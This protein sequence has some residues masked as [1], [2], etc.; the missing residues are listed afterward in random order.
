MNIIRILK[1][2]NNWL[3]FRELLQPLSNKEKG[4]CFELLTWY[5]LKLEPK[6][7]SKLDFVWLLNE[8]PSKV[9]RHI[10]LP[11]QDEGIDLLAKTKEGEYWAIQCKYRDDENL[12]LTRK[13]LSTFTDLS[14]SICKNISLG[15]VCTTTCGYS[16][17]L[18]LYGDRVA[19]CT[20]NDWQKLDSE[21]FHRLHRSFV[22]EPD[23]IEPLKPRPHQEDAITNAYNHF[24]VENNTRGKMIMP[25]GTGKSLAAYWITEQLD[26]KRILVL[27]PSIALIRQTLDVWLRQAIADNKTVSWICVCSDQTLANNDNYDSSIS[28][29]DLGIQIHTNP[30]EIENWLKIKRDG[31]TVIFST[32]Q[33]GKALSEAS[34][35]AAFTFDVG[36][37]DEAHKTVG[38]KQGL[39]S[40]PLSDNFISINKRIFMTATERRYQGNNNN[41]VGM[42]DINVYGETFELLSF[43][44]ALDM[45][46]PILCNYKIAA[47]I[48]DKSEI[49]E[50]IE[51]NVFLRPNIDE[52]DDFI[53]AQML[54]S[55]V[56]LRK[57]FDDWPIKH[58]VSFHKSIDRAKKYKESMELLNKSNNIS[59]PPDCYHVSGKTPISVRHRIMDDFAKSDR[60]IITNARCLTEGVDIPNIDCILFADPKR[61]TV[62]IVQAV[63]RAMRPSKGK[64]IGYIIIPILT[65]SEID[66]LEDLHNNKLTNSLF[67]FHQKTLLNPY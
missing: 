58:A 51:E 61:S 48:V 64:N 19:F 66:S 33:S 43:K 63:G 53:E 57:A 56:A 28:V 17:K 60:S 55:V 30:N 2:A 59:M 62:D 49:A 26:A 46:P 23:H 52:W 47:I 20:S 38:D 13:E 31:L 24:I 7:A 25:C 18:K 50:L 45:D 32:Y 14:F 42:D 11:E 34:R 16:R 41:I 27:V 5:Y 3:E 10:N 4:D 15:I 8:I 1:Q 21:F 37:F 65:N 29:Q 40:L 22:N 9:R 12:S 36:I 6:Y 35:K 67:E 39:F 54:A 44:E